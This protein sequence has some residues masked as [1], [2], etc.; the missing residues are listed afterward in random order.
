VPKIFPIVVKKTSGAAEVDLSWSQPP[1]NIQ[2]SLPE[3]DIIDQS[4]AVSVSVTAPEIDL[5]LDQTQ[6]LA[7]AIGTSVSEVDIKPNA[8]AVAIALSLPEVDV[9][10]LVDAVTI[11]ANA[12]SLDCC[13]TSSDTVVVPTG[14][15][16]AKIECWAGGAGGGA[17]SVSGGG[18]GGGGAY[19]RTNV[20]AV[21]PGHTLTVTVGTGGAAAANGN[22]SLVKDGATTFTLAKGGTA[23]ATGSAGGQGAGGAGGQAS[24]GT[25][26][27]KF[28]GGT[29][30][31]GGGA[32]TPNGGGGGGGAGDANAGGAG[33]SGGGAGTGGPAGGG[34]G[35]AGGVTT[36]PAGPGNTFGGAGG[37]ASSLAAAAAGAN[38]QVCITFSNTLSPLQFPNLFAWYR[39]DTVTLVSSKVHVWPDKSGN[40][41]ANRD[42]IASNTGGFVDAEYSSSE[43]SF[44]NLPIVGRVGGGAN[45]N[46]QWNLK[47]RGA[48]SSNPTTISV[49]VVFR[50]SLDGH[51]PV[52]AG[53]ALATML[54][55]IA[56]DASPSFWLKDDVGGAGHPWGMRMADA[57]GSAVIVDGNPSISVPHVMCLVFARVDATHMN[58]TLFVDNWS[59]ASFGPTS[60]TD[61]SPGTTFN[62]MRIA[63]CI[64]DAESLPF[65]IAEC[66]VYAADHSADSVTRKAIMQ[67]YL[68]QR[69]NLT[70][71]P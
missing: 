25:G 59:V 14:Y 9:A 28:S 37:G 40:G 67:T 46:A 61:V 41:D 64:A 20:Q 32:G 2:A 71:N 26:D 38:G 6:S 53:D 13:F 57:T 44:N 15:T 58:F 12:S 39:A 65:G 54:S 48:F 16:A 30:G 10:A 5:T 56:L 11:A 66:A 34:A 62:V 52:T 50:Y 23:G 49:Y 33:A 42:L 19:S 45:A 29:G 18:G 17:A 1:I 27:V 21:T 7:V 51:Q 8:L 63:S 35:G 69:Y 24:A 36:T 68:G 4:S 3:I 31:G 60:E 47:N 55:D 43:S 22:D 70:V